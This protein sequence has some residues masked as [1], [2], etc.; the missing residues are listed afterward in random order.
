M[1]KNPFRKALEGWDEDQW[2]KGEMYDYRDGQVVASCALGRLD[3]M[4]AVTSD[5]VDTYR[6]ANHILTQTF[7]ALYPDR[8]HAEEDYGTIPTV[9][10]HEDTTFEDVRA[11][12]EKAAV[13][14][15]EQV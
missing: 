6:L 10:D 12:F 3:Y 4:W 2:I 7:H 8:C 13:R 15:D 14:W 11:A 9:N 1:E 5:S